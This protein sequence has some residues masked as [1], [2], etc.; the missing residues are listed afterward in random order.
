ME[1]KT[2]QIIEIILIILV[3]GTIAGEIYLGYTIKKENAELKESLQQNIDANAELTRNLIT[4]TQE[5]F[6]KKIE[7]IASAVEEIESESKS[8]LSD[9]EE[10]V[11]NVNIKSGDFSAILEDVFPGVVNIATDQGRGSGAIITDDG[12]IVTNYH[13][14]KDAQIIQVV[15]Y[16]K[17]IYTAIPIGAHVQYDVAVLKINGSFNELQF[18]DSSKVKVG[19][20]VVAVG[21]PAGLGFS[22]TEGII[23][24]TERIISQQGPPMIQTDVPINPGNSGGPLINTQGNIV[25]INRLKIAGYESLGFAIPSNLVKQ[26]AEEII[27]RDI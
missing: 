6:Q 7:T 13:V 25:G 21:N 3:V 8:R 17:R 24:Q 2:I 16:N 20:R 1:K 11:K 23:S 19:E 15:D 5:D 26:V 12:H 4:S 27:Q 9:L 22:V 10:E 18:A 14:I